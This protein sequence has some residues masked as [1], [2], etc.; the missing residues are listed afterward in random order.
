MSTRNRSP[1]NSLRIDDSV[2]R[3]MFR[4][5]GP[6]ERRLGSF[7]VT[8]DLLQDL[9]GLPEGA[10]IVNVYKDNSTETMSIVVTSEYMPLVPEGAVIPNVKLSEI[11]GWDE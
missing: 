1:F 3:E 8:F 4:M 10:R 11:K 7:R 5:P 6:E 2:I 9:L